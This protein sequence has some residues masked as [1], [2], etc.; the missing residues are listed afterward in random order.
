[1]LES[2]FFY[3]FRWETGK[4]G[5]IEGEKEK[6]GYILKFPKWNF[7]LVAWLNPCQYGGSS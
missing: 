4:H 7:S 5:K 3:K 6:H 1:M 2:D